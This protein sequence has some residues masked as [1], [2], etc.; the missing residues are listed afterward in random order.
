MKRIVAATAI[1]V[2]LVVT[3]FGIWYFMSSLTADSGTTESITIEE[4]PYESYGLIYIAEDQGLFTRNGLN[5]TMRNYG[6]PNLLNGLLSD[7]VD[8]GL[9]SE[10]VFVRKVFNQANISVIGNIDRYQNVYLIGRKDKGI[11]KVSDL[12]GKKIGLTRNTISEFYLGRFLDLHGMSIRDVTL[13]NMP[14]SQYM[15]AITNGSIEALLTGNFIDQIQERLGNNAV[16][17]PTQNGQNS[18]YVMSCRSDWAAGH[19]VQINRFLKSLAQAEDYMINHPNEAKAIIQKRL[20][21][22]DAYMAK[23]WPKN[24]F[25]LSLDQS[26]VLAMEDEGRWMIANNLTT[27][28]TIPDIRDHIYTKGLEGVLPESVNVI[29]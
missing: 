2:A 1:M 20:N 29:A 4:L 16:L 26:L 13:S 15:Q 9:S 12:S 7:E 10:Y 18:Y 22:T 27:A 19:P 11:E 5:V 28:K 14:P 17:W 23:I 6:V 24:E 8:I 25:S 3:G 21:Y